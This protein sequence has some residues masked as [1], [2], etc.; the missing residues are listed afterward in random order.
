MGQVVDMK[1]KALTPGIPCI[2]H[3]ANGL[4]F[5]SE[6]AREDGDSFVFDANR[7]LIVTIGDANAEGKT[8][9]KM[10]KMIGWIFSP[11]QIRVQKTHIGMIQDCGQPELI[12]QFQAALSGLIAP[13]EAMN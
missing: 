2:Y 9:L 8:E 5:Y 10:K 7:S 11:Q 13:T 1:G 12:K 6:T 4:C 3:L